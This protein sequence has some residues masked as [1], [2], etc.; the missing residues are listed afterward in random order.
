M[1]VVLAWIIIFVLPV[2]VLL[3]IGGTAAARRPLTTW[4]AVPALVGISTTVWLVY[5]G[6]YQHEIPCDG[7]TTGCPTV[8]GYDAPL[9]DGHV[10]GLV[11][12]L[13]AFAIPALWIGW[14]RLATP[15]T[16]GV[17][18]AIGPIVLAW[19]TTPRGDNDGL[20]I[21]VFFGLPMLGGLAALLA[22][23]AGR[24]GDHAA[25]PDAERGAAGSGPTN[26]SLS[27]RVA[28]LAIDVAVVGA[29]GVVP[30]TMLTRA[31]LEVVAAVLGIGA[32]TAYL[33][34]PLARK[35][36][37]VGQSLVGLFVVDVATG[38]P[39][40][41]TRAVARSLIVVVEVV[42]LPTTIFAVPALIEVISLTRC[43][44]TVTDRL[45]G[46]DVLSGRRQVAHAPAPTVSD[47][48]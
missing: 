47:P 4:T 35:G 10:A 44:R 11:L 27:D 37:T 29:V 13:A 3:I 33:A 34:V 12:V 15:F 28:A 23:V 20:W 46:T 9:P 22:S 25:M 42:A 14:R 24:V 16:T 41:A 32:A 43:G 40:S 6:L 39:I 7:R 5:A 21:L 26:A 30:L 2:V 18:L 19:W 45:L 1:D 48:A 38:R 36:R 17:S 31:H 8:Y